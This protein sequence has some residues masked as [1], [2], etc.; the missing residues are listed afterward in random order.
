MRWSFCKYV[1][2]KMI[3]ASDL[4]SPMSA[5]FRLDA[6]RRKIRYKNSVSFMKIINPHELLLKKI[7]NVRYF[8]Y[9]PHVDK[10]THCVMDHL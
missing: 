8:F 10:Q 7:D 4:F 3:I 2:I 5:Q 1:L 9:L 6:S